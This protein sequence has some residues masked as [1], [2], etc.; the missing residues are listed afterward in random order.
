MGA[1]VEGTDEIGS[2]CDGCGRTSGGFIAAGPG[3]KRACELKSVTIT[4]GTAVRKVPKRGEW[5]VR[6][7]EGIEL[8]TGLVLMF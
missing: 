7:Q 2:R 5:T 6:K 4:G 1:G 3:F 8:I